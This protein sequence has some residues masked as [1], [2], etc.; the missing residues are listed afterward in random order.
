MEDPRGLTVDVLPPIF[1]LCETSHDSVG[2]MWLR[3]WFSFYDLTTT[4]AQK[5]QDRKELDRLQ[6]KY[7]SRK[8]DVLQK[9]A[10]DHFVN[11]RSRSHW[12]RLYKLKLCL[13][14]KDS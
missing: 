13:V 8:L 14:A 4:D 10:S 1:I 6:E 9:R 11:D 12:K 2:H 5:D 3:I 7:G